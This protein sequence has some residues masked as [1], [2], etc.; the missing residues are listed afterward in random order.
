MPK[1]KIRESALKR[2]WHAVVGDA[3]DPHDP[4]LTH[5]LSLVAFLAW[6]GLGVDG[7]SSSAY[8]P[9]EAY[10]ALGEHGYL[11]IAL[12]F[13]TGFT[14]LVISY[15][16]SR[17]IEQF[18][19]GGGGY[20]VA[21]QLLGRTPGVISGCA[22]LVDYVLTIT[23]SIASGGD[24][25]FSLL[26]LDFQPYKLPIEFCGIILLVF[27]NLRGLK[28]S[29]KV[30]VPF[31][32]LF[33][34]THIILIFGGILFHLT[35]FP[36]LFHNTTTGFK[37]GVSSVGAWGLF[38]I[39]LRSYCMGGGTYT[40]IEAVSNGVGTLAEPKVLT[41][42]K[43]MLYLASSLSI[44][45]GGLL[46]CYMLYQ[47]K[48]VEGQTLNA[49][50]AQSFAG[51]W[52]FL[53][54]PIGNGFVWATIFSESVLLFVAA[55]TGFIDGP[56]VMANMAVDSW[57][58]RRFAALSDRLTM[59]NG[60][61]V[62]GIAALATLFYTKG[63]ITTLVV[64]YSINV[65][66]TFSM[67][68]AAMVKHW[69]SV[70]KT[71]P[72]WKRH[73]SV[74]VTGFFLCFSILVVMILEKFMEG[75]WATLV[76]TSACIG[77]SVYIK[78]HYLKI[79]HRIKHIEGKIREVTRPGAVMRKVPEFDP[80][81]PIAAIL[82]GGYSKLGRRSLLAVLRSFPKT[83][84]NVV[85]LSVGVVN[86]EFFKKGEV[87]TLQ[88]RTE[89]TLKGYEAIANRMGM[90]ARHAYRVGTDVVHEASELCMDIA[91]QYTHVIFFAGE[92][93]FEHP[94]WFDRFLHNET[95][96]AIQR[97]IRH[98]GLSMVILPLVL[99]DEENETIELDI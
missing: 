94:H 81:Q 48:P 84:H 19:H 46:L 33:L 43:T 44:T 8:G 36:T 42:K 45:A 38:L 39:F 50:L 89:E 9:E 98:A 5:K 51:D 86:S 30:I 40:G 2:F 91:K 90:P 18:P 37:S 64:M 35:D 80:A 65:F 3:R 68:E 25:I 41:G 71:D 58:P 87:N 26:P 85:F 7:L 52:K 93:V 4:E 14:V 62:M 74:H 77:I 88:K 12:M 34:T 66:I 23:V 6:V 29:V 10:R 27:L 47:V 79:G 61:V 73:S 20:I 49:V 28:E 56:R 24:A 72:K 13:A 16:Y 96:Y 78:R 76:I 31:F 67:T 21:T 97:H 54:L 1:S 70:R 32:I 57:L 82:V 22:L 83:F 63:K 53:G 95:A 60:I 92:L 17:L 75:A 69:F 99:H 55:Q 11:A 59:Q 15:A